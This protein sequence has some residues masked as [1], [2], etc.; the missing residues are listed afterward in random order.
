MDSGSGAGMTEGR[1]ARLAHL[2]PMKSP[3]RNCSFETRITLTLLSEPAALAL[4][5]R[6]IYDSRQE[7]LA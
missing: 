1:D 6:R 4:T 2:R 3:L 7:T 5:P